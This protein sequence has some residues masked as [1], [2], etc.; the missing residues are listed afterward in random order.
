MDQSEAAGETPTPVPGLALRGKYHF[1][2][3][4]M[5]LGLGKLEAVLLGPTDNFGN[6]RIVRQPIL[7][8]AGQ[9]GEEA[10]N[11]LLAHG[12]SKI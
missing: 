2:H 11:V 5:Q 6:D 12:N 4:A 3:G 8:I 1:L 9:R 10:G 7:A